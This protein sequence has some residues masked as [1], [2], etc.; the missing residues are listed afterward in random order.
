MRGRS[1]DPP[2][3]EVAPYGGEVVILKEKWNAV[4]LSGALKGYGSPSG[5]SDSYFEI[6]IAPMDATS[7]DDVFVT[8][9]VEGGALTID[10]TILTHENLKGLY[11]YKVGWKAY[12]GGTTNSTTT[13]LSE[14]VHYLP[15]PPFDVSDSG[16]EFRW[17]MRSNQMTLR[18]SV[19]QDWADYFA[20]GQ[21]PKG[22]KVQ[23]QARYSVDQGETFSS[24]RNFLGWGGTA[25]NA[26]GSGSGN[27]FS[28]YNHLDDG[29]FQNLSYI[30]V[31]IRI[32]DTSGINYNPTGPN[33]GKTGELYTTFFPAPKTVLTPYGGRLSSF[34]Y[35]SGMVT[36]ETWDPNRPQRRRLMS[37]YAP[38]Y[39]TRYAT[40]D[41]GVRIAEKVLEL[42]NT[43]GDIDNPVSFI[44]WE[45][46][47]S[48]DF[49]EIID[50]RDGLA[51]I[52]QLSAGV[53]NNNTKPIYV[54]F[55]VQ[56]AYWLKE[57]DSTTGT[58]R[59][60]YGILT[61]EYKYD[62]VLDSVYP[63]W[64]IVARKSAKVPITDMRLLENGEITPR[65]S[66]DDYTWQIRAT[67]G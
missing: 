22:Y 20:A 29:L 6:G 63:I 53:E 30:I 56:L 48:P 55:Y 23:L 62:V 27:L 16:I 39:L 60:D 49:S 50:S 43:I 19:H 26:S 66:N 25:F 54:R 21:L 65:N 52:A 47:Y 33:T 14:E 37:F 45:A 58:R 31:Q 41:E 2:T 51:P 17:S 9:R 35:N 42:S 40:T 46:S 36:W 32:A 15:P 28:W 61:D 34:G 10:E 64:G 18:Y 24:W 12:N 3:T 7:Y 44:R 38:N 57:G 11:G 5:G 4:T 67:E 13:Y 59:E 8:K 1:Y